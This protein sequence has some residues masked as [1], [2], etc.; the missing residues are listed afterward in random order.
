MHQ[1]MIITGST[2]DERKGPVFTPWISGIARN[3]PDW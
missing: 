1:L 3:D 2:R